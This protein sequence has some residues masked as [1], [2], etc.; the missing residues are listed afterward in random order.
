MG[1]A[2]AADIIFKRQI[3]NAEDPE[4][5]RERLVDEFREKVASPLE[6]GKLGLVDAIIMPRETRLR[7]IR[8]LEMTQGK[9][10]PCL[11]RKHGNMPT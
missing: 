3:Q 6:A 5:E 10:V 11:K 9:R 4:R 8:A 1:P 2:G 7:L